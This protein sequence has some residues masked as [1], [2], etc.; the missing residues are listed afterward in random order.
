LRLK[1]YNFW[2]FLAPVFMC[3]SS[4]LYSQFTAFSTTM[5]HWLGFQVIQGIGVGLGMQMSSLTI[6]LELNDEPILV[7][8]G[9]A[10]VTFMQFLGGTVVQVIAGAVFNNKLMDELVS[11]ANL[12]DLQIDLLLDG[13]VTHIRDTIQRYFPSRLDLVLESYNSAITTVF[14]SGFYQSSGHDGRVL[15]RMI[16]FVPV[17]G[18]AAAFFLAFGIKWNRIPDTEESRENQ[19]SESRIEERKTDPAT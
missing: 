15:T 17:A 4:I 6:Q 18:T 19:P 11:H 8:I 9:I 14:V 2:F 12:T 7:P 16:Q 3:T 13:G 1:Y 5:S 10:L